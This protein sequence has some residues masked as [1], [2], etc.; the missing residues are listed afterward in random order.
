[1]RFIFLIVSTFFLTTIQATAFD[2]Q[3]DQQIKK[4]LHSSEFSN[5]IVQY[6]F[7]G[8][9]YPIVIIHNPKH[10]NLMGKYYS[11]PIK[12]ALTVSADLPFELS[13][14]LEKKLYF[15]WDIDDND[16]IVDFK[17]F[18]SKEIFVDLYPV[19]IAEIIDDPASDIQ[20]RA[21]FNSSIFG[22]EVFYYHLGS[23]YYKVR[24]LYNPEKQT[25]T[26]S[27][28]Y[29]LKKNGPLECFT[30]KWDHKY[31]IITDQPV[32]KELIDHLS[33]LPDASYRDWYFSFKV[34]NGTYVTYSETDYGYFSN[35][36]TT[37]DLDTWFNFTEDL[38][39]KN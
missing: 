34:H 17:G 10:E 39:I 35:T 7:D 12:I 26:A 6:R 19:Y 5:S 33:H 3:A 24:V 30:I 29:R 36:T 22:N 8:S 4:I 20:V 38:R 11:S 2:W 32:P 1:M 16:S 14:Y 15:E 27:E 28:K 37:Y 18:Y 23:K 21:L 31:G 25:Y 13:H 9:Q